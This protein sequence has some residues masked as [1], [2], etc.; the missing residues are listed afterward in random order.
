MADISSYVQ[1]FGPFYSGAMINSYLRVWNVNPSVSATAQA[2]FLNL[3]G[4]VEETAVLDLDPG[5]V[6]QFMPSLPDGLVG[7]VQ[8]T[9][10]QPVVG[11][12]Q[13]QG[14]RYVSTSEAIQ[15]HGA[16]MGD[17]MQS[18]PRA[19]KDV[20]EG[21]GV[22]ITSF[23]V[24]NAG[25]TA[26]DVTLTFYD[27]SGGSAHQQNLT[28]PVGGAQ[29]V[30]L[31][32]IDTLAA[33]IY[34]VVAEG[35]VPIV[36]GEETHYG[37]ATEHAAAAYA[38]QSYASGLTY[39]LILPHAAAKTLIATPFSVMNLGSS[40]ANVAVDYYSAAGSQVSSQALSLPSGQAERHDPTDV[41]G[42]PTDFEGSV[43][44]RA[45]QPIAAWVDIYQAPPCAPVSN[46]QLS[47][48]PEGTLYA[49]SEISF[50]VTADGSTPFT[51]TWG[52]NGTAVGTNADTW[53][54]TFDE[55]GTFTV[56]VEVANV[57]STVTASLPVEILPLLPDLSSSEKTVNLKYVDE[58]DVLTYTL[59]LR[60]SGMITASASLTDPLPTA[61]TYISDT[62]SVSSGEATVVN[63]EVR[64]QGDVGVGNPVVLQ[65]A[66]NFDPTGLTPGDRVTNTAQLDDG[67]GTVTPHSVA[68]TY[69]PGYRVTINDG[70]LFTND[71]HVDLNIAWADVDPAINQLWI[72]NDA[73]LTTGTG[74]ISVTTSY[75][76][77]LEAYDLETLSRS[78]YVQFRD[79]EGRK[80]GP[81]DDDII[82][83]PIKPEITGVEVISTTG[84]ADVTIRAGTP[85]TVRV[86][87]SDAESGT[88]LLKLSHTMD[89]AD[90]TTFPVAGETTAV[91]WTLQ[92]SGE[93][94]VR[95]IDR[96]G[97]ESDIVNQEGQRF[98][99]VYL[100][101]VIRND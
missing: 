80:Y 68:V 20:S 66:T 58:R 16:L 72:S 38:G 40:N 51:Y 2:A 25:S 45:D 76:W 29:L 47:R 63:D 67:A 11:L 53:S 98:S 32:D 13:T 48:S 18:L 22:R 88:S 50:S 4:T 97:N 69:N 44:L 1:Y 77:Q 46:V 62:L 42:L 95:V 33:G 82:L 26:G 31:G 36:L 41:A 21:G 90:F 24:A 56:S 91:P 35:S 12:L 78:V 15:F 64:W 9:S 19:F 70:A 59:M 86:T 8:L 100:P 10:D 94:F 27:E 101:L 85:V 43:A 60:N 92:T 93:V 6:D 99:F 49:G 23:L 55:G 3:D 87:A 81:I 37:A 73:G 7:W 28:L 17:T 52:L 79:A 30:D 83:D 34:S 65:F 71:P 57:C 75:P 84:G 54:H 74:W 61:L 14:N 39:S 89:F 96:A 5:A